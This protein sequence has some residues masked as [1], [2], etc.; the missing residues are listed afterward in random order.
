MTPLEFKNKW[1]TDTDTLFPLS[2]DRLQNLNLRQTTIDFLNEAGLPD[3]VAPYLSL[4]KD[5][6]DLFDGI[7]KLTKQYDFLEKEYEKFVVIGADGSGNPL[8]ID[9]AEGDK[10][11]W[12]DHEDMFSSR[13]VN[14][15]ISELAETLL[16]YRDFISEILRDN[17]EDAYLDSNFTDTQFEA[18]KQKINLVD[19][20]ALIEDGFWKDELEMLLANRQDYLANK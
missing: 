4:V 12:L 13:Y 2:I 18:L 8:A 11:V 9:T 14:R 3:N 1:T 16:I 6:S 10:I 5:T 19:S 20:Q 7:N 17:G 15:S